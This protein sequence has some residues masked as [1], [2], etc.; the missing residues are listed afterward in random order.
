MKLTN[1][2]SCSMITATSLTIVITAAIGLTLP[3]SVTGQEAGVVVPNWIGYRGNGTGVFPADCAPPTQWRAYTYKDGP[4]DERGRVQYRIK[5]KDDPLNIVWKTDV[6]MYCNG[7]MIIVD[8]KLLFMRDRNGYKFQYYKVPDFLGGELVCL[9]AKTGKELWRHDC[10][11]TDQLP[12]PE[13]ARK[14]IAESIRWNTE[15]RG[16]WLRYREYAGPLRGGGHGVPNYK[17]NA[18][19]GWFEEY[20]KR[21]KEFQRYWPK[22]PLTAE[23]LIALDGK[24]MPGSG[25]V[26]NYM[27]LDFGRFLGAAKAWMPEPVALRDKVYREYGYGYGQWGGL[28]DHFGTAIATPVSDGKFIYVHTAFND[29][30]CIDLNGKRV[31]TT[32]LGTSANCTGGYS[33]ILC[34]DLLIGQKR[35]ARDPLSL[36]AMNKQT[37]K[38]VWEVPALKGHKEGNTYHS[39]VRLRLPIAGTNQSLDVIYHCVTG[40]I[41]RL[42]DGKVVAAQLP[43]QPWRGMSFWRD[44]VFVNNRKGGIGG[45]S[46]SEMPE[47]LIGFRL[48]AVSADQVDAELVW[49]KPERQWQCEVTTVVGDRLYMVQRG[50]IMASVDCA[51]GAQE[52]VCKDRAVDAFHLISYAGGHLYTTGDD[53]GRW[54]VWKVNSD[55]IELVAINNLAEK[56]IPGRADFQYGGQPLFSGNR[57]FIRSDSTVYC[58]GDPQQP[59]RL[60]PVHDKK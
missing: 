22:V 6:D 34:D 1:K 58:L 51:T 38:I 49:H 12:N 11:H 57:M 54:G 52:I 40:Q 45:S 2:Q 14:E 39:P 9:D 31:W 24:E 20:A 53:G 48:K 15:T 8:G 5:D 59:T 36:I 19:A 17:E 41:I 56:E 7:G 27:Q 25:F 44:M 42:S 13:Q 55:S 32:Y 47:G 30:F 23:E 4:K 33:P 16:A 21:A 50:A 28:P 29:Y 60:S 18:P 46:Q 37:G 35:T 26:W 10:E 43:S 3:A